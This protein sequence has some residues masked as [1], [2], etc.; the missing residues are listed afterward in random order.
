VPG[1]ITTV[2]SKQEA[3]EPASVTEGSAAS[4]KYTGRCSPKREH[5]QDRKTEER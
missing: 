2:L 5:K 1:T 3:G 4:S